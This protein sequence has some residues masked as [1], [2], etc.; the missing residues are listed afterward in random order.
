[1]TKIH[2]TYVLANQAGYKFEIT[3]MGQYEYDPLA[4]FYKENF[5]DV[6]IT[7]PNSTTDLSLLHSKALLTVNGYVHNTV[8][9]DNTL[10]I[11]NAS[12]SLLKHKQN[13]IGILSFN[14]LSQPLKKIKLID[15][16][17]TG[18]TSV[19]LFEKTVITFDR[20]VGSVF[21]VIAGY[22]IFEQPEFF[23][24]VS[25]SSFVLR[26]DRLNYVEK[27]YELNTHRNIFDE[28]GVDVSPT[29]PSLV[30]GTQLRSD[31][32]IRKFLT[33]DNSFLV[34]VPCEAIEAKPIYLE[35]STVPGSF[36]TEVEPVYPIITGRGKIAEYFKQKKNDTKYT[37]YINDA[38]YQN[39]LFSHLPQNQIKIYNDHRQPGSTYQLSEAFFLQ[40][41]LTL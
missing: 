34:E 10:Y 31:A 35:H 8:Y 1:M 19:P 22:L 21:L 29:D 15:S 30:D 13:N 24:R 25:G 17:L 9:G 38:Y 33:L 11:P 32:V 23:Y 27:L 5:P 3:K 18:E 16:M 2:P 28:V 26:L 41:N 37:V 7:R 12:S 36:R 20:E 6:K 39:Y 40:I 4:Y 14:Q